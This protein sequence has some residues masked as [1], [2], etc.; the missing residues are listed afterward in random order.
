MSMSHK[1]N[2]FALKM[3]HIVG[4]IL[5]IT[6]IAA[7]MHPAY[8]EQAGRLSQSGSCEEHGIDKSRCF[9]CDPSLREKGRLWCKE[10]RRYEDRCWACHPDLKEKGRLFCEEHGLYEDECIFCHPETTK[11]G[12]D[13]DEPSSQDQLASQDHSALFCKE[14]KVPEQECGICH[15]ELATE[16]NPGQSMMIRFSSRQSA[17]KAGL[18]TALPSVSLSS[19]TIETFCEVKYNENKLAR[20]TPLASGVI[21][22]VL[23]D[24]GD[25]VKAGDIL[26]QVNSAE[27]AEA[28][29]SFLSAIADV[30]V[31]EIANNRKEKLV[32]EKISAAREYQEAKASYDIAVLTKGTARQRLLNY[33]FTDAE[34][35]QIK[36]ARDSSSFLAVRAPFHGTLVDRAAVVG[37]VVNP[38][39]ALFTLADLKS[40]WL[41]LSIPEDQS[42]YA[43]QGQNV[44]ATFDSRAGVA[45]GQ[46]IW[47]ATSIDERSRM[48]KARA[49]I[50]NDDGKIKSGMF[51]KAEI[52]TGQATKTFRIPKDAIQRLDGK[53]Y[54]FVKEDADLFALR[55][56][57]VRNVTGSEIDVLTGINETDQIVIQGSFIVMSEFL[58][59]RLGAGCTDG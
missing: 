23:V 40:M 13:S 30:Q 57:V 56:I 54:L 26:V 32:K 29:A 10:H 22:R 21:Q 33:G 20:I 15:P 1:S 19:P 39:N 18:R 52:E 49:V 46:L 8:S 47:V 35:E 28:K 3:I 58:K 34:I 27:I 4:S 25:Q 48:L 12:G 16:L 59:S 44:E 37:E 43:E 51:G 42:R 11:R 5:I 50:P 53:P 45:K 41:E 7:T 9:I 24:V 17:L 2:V 31:K 14:H 38:G 36:K 55:R 6:A